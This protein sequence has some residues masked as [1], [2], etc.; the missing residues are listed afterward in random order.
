MRGTG[1]HRG[2]RGVK[3]RRTISL[4]SVV[5][6]IDGLANHSRLGLGLDVATTE[7]DTSN[8]SALALVEA[9][10]LDFI[11]RLLLR[12]K[13]SDPEVTIGIITSLLM[14]IA[15]RR[16]RKLC[17]DATSE[18]FFAADV[19]R[20]LSPLVPVD[21]VVS[22]E[23]ILYLGEKMSVKAFLGNQLINEL[24]DGHLILPDETWVKDDFRLVKRDRGSFI[25]EVDSN[26]GHGD[27]FDAVKLAI[28]AAKGPGGPS[29]A[30]PAQ[31]GS[32][33][34][35]RGQGR[36]KNPMA[37]LFRGSGGKVNV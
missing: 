5:P 26:G 12:W 21:L 31:V 18:K 15:P 9:V 4:S 32:F 25:T 28:H 1:F 34:A 20:R 10:N 16:A 37:H 6:Q 11:V 3:G 30:T 29:E 33:G 14:R 8:P 19:K 13:T 27:G 2:D 17:V 22:S 7:K 24:D 35:Q 23:S 36:W